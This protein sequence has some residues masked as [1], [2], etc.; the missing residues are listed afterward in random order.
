MLL[1]L[2]RRVESIRASK[3]ITCKDNCVNPLFL[4]DGQKPVIDRPVTMHIRR[5]EYFHMQERWLTVESRSITLRVTCRSRIH[6]FRYHCWVLSLSEGA[7][8][9]LRSPQSW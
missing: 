5:S 2:L 1:C 6:S 3:K 8:R 7:Q 9:I 4:G